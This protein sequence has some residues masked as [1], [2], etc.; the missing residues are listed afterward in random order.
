MTVLLSVLA[1]AFVA[2]VSAY[3]CTPD[4]WTGLVTNWDPSKNFFSFGEIAYDYVNKREYFTAVEEAQFPQRFVNVTYILLYNSQT[5]YAIT[6][7]RGTT[8]CKQF[9]LEYQMMQFCVEPPAINRHNV[10][11]G[12]N[13]EASV[14]HYEGQNEFGIAIIAEDAGCIPVS[15]RQFFQRNRNAA[16]EQYFDVVN[17]VNG[18]LFNPPSF[19]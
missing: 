11:I 5:G 16:E 8:T 14:Y 10:T 1:L 9:P 3:C 6:E 18:G 4:Q 12:E 19:C 17:S 7:D 15:A 2:F 13:L